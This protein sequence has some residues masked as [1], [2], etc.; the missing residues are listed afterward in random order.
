MALACAP[1]KPETRGGER[2]KEASCLDVPV[3]LDPGLYGLNI[4]ERDAIA[5]AADDGIVVVRYVADGCAVKLRILADCH[6]GGA[7]AYK[8]TKARAHKL[9]KSERALLEW[10]PVAGRA[11]TEAFEQYGALRFDEEIVGR[12][13]APK[14]ANVKALEGTRCAGATHVATAI[15]VGG[16]ALSAGS[17]KTL[18]DKQDLFDERTRDVHGVKIVEQLGDAR[19]CVKALRRGERTVGCD[20]PLRIELEPLGGKRSEGPKVAAK[21]PKAS[22]ESKESKESKDP[23]ETQQARDAKERPKEP[24][25]P[26]KPREPVERGAIAFPAGEFWMGIEGNDKNQSP[27]HKV[28]LDAFE[29]DRTEVTAAD[30]GHCLHEGACPPAK[31]GGNCTIGEASR[32]DHP[33]NCVTFAGAK[34]YCAFKKRRLPTEAEWERAARGTDERP[35]VWGTE[36]PPP[37]AV[38]NFADEAS[39]RAHPYWL[40]L[41]GYDDENAE[42]APVGSY[43]KGQAPSG[44]L[45][46]AGNVSEWTADFYQDR[47]YQ[48]SPPR[49]PKGPPSG[50]A[51]V[52]RGGSFGHHLKVHLYATARAAYKEDVASEHV[53]FRCAQSLK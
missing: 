25:P 33:A 28:Y 19:S 22:K 44:A 42:T 1:L 24:K 7:Y 50:E 39:K 2:D 45:D 5:R 18:D 12:L 10:L 11:A 13:E 3:P 4:K 21:E 20:F 30:Y 47:F 49:N 36:W 48:R 8:A 23:K 16:S 41:A 9:V 6:A 53:G 46:M 26:S 31:S 15:D 37:D 14:S 27:R 43:P 35:F 32:A 17:A 38:G 40:V 29:I 51:R 34:A 52:V